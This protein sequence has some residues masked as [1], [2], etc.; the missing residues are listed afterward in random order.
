MGNNKATV[1]KN[2]SVQTGMPVDAKTYTSR[3]PNDLHGNYGWERSIAIIG[4]VAMQHCQFERTR[5]AWHTGITP[6][7]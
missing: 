4:S 1:I 5:E 6:S 7:A 3:K 2:R